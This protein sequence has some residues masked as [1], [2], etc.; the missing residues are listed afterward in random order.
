MQRLLSV[1]AVVGLVLAFAST[2]GAADEKK[3]KKE[4][5]KAPEA[6]ALF[7]KLDTNGDGKLSKDEFNAFKGVGKKADAG[8]EPKG[9]A[10]TRDD[11]FAKLDTNKDG[12]I[13]KEEFGKLKQVMTDNPAK[14]KK[15]DK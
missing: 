13:S 7:T 6:T 10:S 11:W 4:K 14:K 5:G 8:K 2:A 15:A 9:F 12:S 3:K 1:A